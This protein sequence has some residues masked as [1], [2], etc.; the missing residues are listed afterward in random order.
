MVSLVLGCG[1]NKSKDFI[2]IDK[3][4]HAK[5]DI[6]WDLEFG[7]PP[8]IE[9]GSVGRVNAHHVLE[10]IKNYE[11]LMFS[12]HKVCKPGATIDILVP[13]APGEP[14]FRDPTHV[15]FFTKNSFLYFDS[16]RNLYNYPHFLTGLPSFS[17]R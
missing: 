11:Q 16:W 17:V 13:E 10:H 4:I 6:L 8:M 15:R 1:P 7:L 5:P 9:E 14:A 12:I 2:N 3:N